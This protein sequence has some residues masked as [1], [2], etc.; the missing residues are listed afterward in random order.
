[1]GL[2]NAIKALVMRVIIMVVGAM[3]CPKAGEH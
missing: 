1:M 3:E 2:V